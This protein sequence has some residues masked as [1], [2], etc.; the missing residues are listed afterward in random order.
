[1]LSVQP[2]HAMNIVA[3]VMAVAAIHEGVKEK[4][5]PN[6]RTCRQPHYSYI[7]ILSHSTMNSVP[8]VRAMYT[9]TLGHCPIILINGVHQS[10]TRKQHWSPL[11]CRRTPATLIGKPCTCGTSVGE[12]CGG[13]NKPF[14]SQSYQAFVAIGSDEINAPIV[15]RLSCRDDSNPSLRGLRPFGLHLC[16]RL[17]ITKDTRTWSNQCRERP[18]MALS[19]C[20]RSRSWVA[21]GSR[22]TSINRCA[23]LCFPGG[24]VSLASPHD[25][26]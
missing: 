19:W 22:Y 20:S 2:I 24:E 26:P 25:P 3:Y 15:L 21:V 17:R 11:K 18:N 16:Q 10:L 5:G 4:K 23:W 13:E 9:R 12:T 1:M 14:D 8:P 6:N 7:C